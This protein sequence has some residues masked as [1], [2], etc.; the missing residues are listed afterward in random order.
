[1]KKRINWKQFS[2]SEERHDFIMISLII[3]NEIRI[4]SLEFERIIGQNPNDFFKCPSCEHEER[5]KVNFVEFIHAL[6]L[7]CPVE[8]D[9]VLYIPFHIWAD[10]VEDQ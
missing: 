5:N 4:T 3:K 10:N 6:D 9:N 7:N 8:K 2:E 1:M